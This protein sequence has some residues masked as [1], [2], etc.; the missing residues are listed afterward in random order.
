MCLFAL[1]KQFYDVFTAS[2]MKTARTNEINEL[3]V[4]CSQ[5]LPSTIDRDMVESE[6]QFLPYSS[7]PLLIETMA[8]GVFTAIDVI[9]YE[10]DRYCLIIGTSKRLLTHFSTAI[11]RLFRYWSCIYSIC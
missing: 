3:V 8:N 10:P 11:F 1:D 7:N 9:E 2:S 4:N 6:K 5:S